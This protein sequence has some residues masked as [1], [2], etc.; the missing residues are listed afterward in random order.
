MAIQYASMRYFNVIWP[1]WL[2]GITYALY[3]VIFA[4]MMLL[5]M[6]DLAEEYG[7]LDSSA[8]RDQ[9]P[10]KRLTSTMVC[11]ISSTRSS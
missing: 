11:S 5:H 6:N 3:L 7:F 8:K 2:A 10:D 9:I 4:S 1:T